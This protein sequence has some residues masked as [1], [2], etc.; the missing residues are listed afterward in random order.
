MRHSFLSLF[1]LERLHSVINS[2]IFNLDQ[3]TG[4]DLTTQWGDSSGHCFGVFK[5]QQREK[6]FKLFY[7]LIRGCTYE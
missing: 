2:N 3:K 5:F 7:F 4:E 6:K 1:E